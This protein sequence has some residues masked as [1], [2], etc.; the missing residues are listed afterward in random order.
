MPPWEKPQGGD[1]P[2][3]RI[4]AQ[5]ARPGFGETRGDELSSSP[6]FCFLPPLVRQAGLPCGL[7][8]QTP[9]VLDCFG[10]QD[11]LG[12][13]FTGARDAAWASA[14]RASRS[15]QRWR[16][17]GRANR[18]REGPAWEPRSASLSIWGCPWRFAGT[19]CMAGQAAPLVPS[20]VM[21][22]DAAGG[23]AISPA[24]PSSSR[25]L[26]TVP[27]QGAGGKFTGAMHAVEA[28][29][30]RARSGG[31]MFDVESG[32]DRSHRVALDSTRWLQAS[33]APPRSS[34]RLAVDSSLPSFA[35]PVTLTR[36]GVQRDARMLFPSVDAACRGLLWWDSAHD[37]AEFANGGGAMDLCDPPGRWVGRHAEGTT[38]A[39]AI[40]RD[41]CPGV[42]S[43]DQEVRDRLRAAGSAASIL[44]ASDSER[45]VPA[46]HLSTEPPVAPRAVKVLRR[47]PLTTMQ[48]FVTPQ[49][50]PNLCI[51]HALARTGHNYIGPDHPASKHQLQ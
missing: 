28:P 43:M 24:R 12:T 46:S 21:D 14:L 48:S 6:G 8:V 41:V 30:L 49:L 34:K 50:S 23:R 3:P 42:L 29:A 9:S 18:L 27:V 36:T 39:G 44:R 15:G 32:G 4:S 25:P 11:R 19:I 26:R 5:K 31:G 10:C 40:S 13:L 38:G 17:E 20:A 45:A 2:T 37:G 33:A 47:I 51:T 1:A 16:R 7:R 35:A 22:R